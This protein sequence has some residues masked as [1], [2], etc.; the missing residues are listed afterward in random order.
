M[1]TKLSTIKKFSSGVRR[2]T[3][4]I[5]SIAAPIGIDAA[6]RVFLEKENPVKA[7]VKEIPWSV[8][9]GIAPA[10]LV[11]GGMIAPAI[12]RGAVVGARQLKETAQQN[13]QD[14]HK[15]GPRFRYQDTEQAVTMRQASVQAI[16]GSKMNARN[17]LGGEAALMHRGYGTRRY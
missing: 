12:A 5:G 3:A 16:Q 9:Y 1:G 8:L 15:I 13:W 7:I 14:T 10:R 11:F 4:G 2:A 6:L 17:A